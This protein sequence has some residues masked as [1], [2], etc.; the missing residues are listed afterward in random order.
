MNK[1]KKL[2]VREEGE[3]RFCLQFF[4][5]SQHEFLCC[6]SSCIVLQLLVATENSLP[7]C[8]VCHDINNLCLDKVLLLFV[9][10]SKCYVATRFS[11]SR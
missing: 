2:R 4:T 5:M 1:N 10:N 7:L 8:F 9:V 11:F 6:H 3:Q